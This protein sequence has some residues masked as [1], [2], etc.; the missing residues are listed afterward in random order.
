MKSKPFENTQLVRSDD[1][2]ALKIKKTNVKSIKQVKLELLAILSLDL[3]ESEKILKIVFLIVEGQTEITQLLKRGFGKLAVQ[4]S[5]LLKSN[6][7]L[8]NQLVDSQ[9]QL[10]NIS[11]ELAD[12][13]K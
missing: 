2:L 11:N 13:K 10:E 3:N 7:Q 1:L 8:N 6:G 12:R 9:K 5:Q 4:N